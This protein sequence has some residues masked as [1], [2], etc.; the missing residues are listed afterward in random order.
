MNVPEDPARASPSAALRPLTSLV[1]RGGELG[2]LLGHLDARRSVRLEASRGAG[3]TALLRAVC[4][5]PPR[6][7]IADGTLALPVGL[8]MNDL[9][10]VAAQLLPAGPTPLGQRQM[11]VLLDDRDLS[12]EDVASLQRTFA[13]SLL[14]VTGDPQADGGDLVPVA[15]HGLSQHHAVGL[16]EAAMG[17]ALSIEEGRAARHVATAVEGMPAPLVQAAAVVRDGGLTFDDVLEVLDDPPRP[18][19]L[20]AALQHA[21][22]DELHVTLSHLR[23]LGDTPATSRVAAAA[24]GLEVGEAERRLR[25]LAVLGLVFTDGRDGWTAASG[26]P[27]VSEPVRAGVA[28]RVA[29]WLEEENEPLDV[30]DAASVMSSVADRVEADDHPA[31]L[32]LAQAALARL[33]LDGLDTT[34]ALL[35]NA[36]TWSIPDPVAPVDEVAAAGAAGG[37]AAAGVAA[38]GVAAAGGESVE[39]EAGD[40]AADDEADTSEAHESHSAETPRA[41]D[42]PDAVEEQAPG[43]PDA[44]GNPVTALFADRRRLALIAVV[45]AAVIAAMLLVVPSLRNDESQP[46][47]VRSDVDLGIAS[48]GESASGTLTLDFTESSATTPVELVLEGPDA[49]AFTVDPQRCDS[50]DCRATLTFTP[51]RSG[52]HVATVRA[53]DSAETELAVANL[54][55]SGTGD[56]PD[57]PVSTNLAVTLFPTEP[58]PIPAGGS[59]VLPVGVR[60]NG[61]DD[62]TGARLVVT[63]PAGTTAEADGCTFDEATL[64]CP[65]AELP[66]GGQER[67]AVALT[68]AQEATEVRVDAEVTP[69]NDTDDAEGDN[70]AGFTYPVAA[71]DDAT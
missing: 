65:L 4:A 2:R 25:R 1:G 44:E 71:P 24:G 38:A 18:T 35:E 14:V 5:E 52:T 16:I 70:A 23:A 3:A 68:V 46:S 20:A 60:N 11:L 8:P 54:T 32:A 50:L 57:V 69:V 28:Q 42:G 62:S 61:P 12:A 15:V 53:L 17:R 21:L 29:A 13:R 51:D 48:V 45:A 7:G 63:V 43:M 34:R 36:T 59:A 6:P 49:D 56:P 40:G 26:I 66:A 10:A 64:T 22:D 9:G 47:V 31:T 30:F 55:G 41:G 67:L 19:A 58:S 33:P 39:D 27:A 37:V